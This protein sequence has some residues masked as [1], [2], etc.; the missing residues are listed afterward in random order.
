VES[1]SDEIWVIQINPEE[2]DDLPR[3]T[4]DIEDRRNELAGNLSLN[5]ELAFVR[6]TN[7]MVR[8]FGEYKDGKLKLVDGS[9]ADEKEYRIIKVRRIELTEPLDYASKLDRS[10]GHVNKLMG[11]YTEKEA[12]P[13]LEA[14]ATLSPFEKAWDEALS[15]W[16]GAQQG[17]GQDGEKDTEDQ[18]KVL[19]DVVNLFADE[20]TIRLVPPDEG[21]SA[22]EQPPYESKEAIRRC[23]RWCLEGNFNLEQARYYRVPEKSNRVAEKEVRWWM[24][25]TTDRFGFPVKGLAKM[26]IEKG[27]IKYFAFYPVD[28]NTVEELEE[29]SREEDR[30]RRRVK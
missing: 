27:K 5:Q 26:I 30:E 10:S 7:E 11:E 3:D 22:S 20:A 15:A 1:N 13:F 9:R 19:D 14:L 25:V 4:A 2:T 17:E 8:R 6:R 12:E 18:A 23:V 24:L 28:M 16:K 21:S 29:R